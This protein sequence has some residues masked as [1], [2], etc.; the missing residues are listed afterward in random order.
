MCL[1]LTL[2]SNHCPRVKGL[3]TIAALLACRLPFLK[4]HAICTEHLILPIQAFVHAV[5]NKICLF[6][7]I[8]VAGGNTSMQIFVAPRSEGCSQGVKSMPLRREQFRQ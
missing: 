3:A 6:S 8:M 1:Q 2:V 4:A 7:S 5:Q